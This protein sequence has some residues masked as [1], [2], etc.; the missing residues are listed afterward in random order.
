MF[1]TLLNISCPFKY[2]ELF[3]RFSFLLL[4]YSQIL[5]CIR[6]KV[7]VRFVIHDPPYKI[8]SLMTYTMIVTHKSKEWRLF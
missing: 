8:K 3:V 1:F 7:F 2:K 4:L 6:R 5:W